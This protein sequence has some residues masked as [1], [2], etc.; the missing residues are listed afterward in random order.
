MCIACNPG[1]VAF[2]RSTASR[3]DFLKYL[4]AAAATSAFACSSPGMAFAQQAA[5]PAGDIVFK[6]GT[7]LTMNDKAPRA[8]AIAI[9]GNKIL[10]VGKLDDV[11]SAIGSGAQVVDLQ[12]RTL[13]PGLIDPHMHFVFTAFED[14]IDVSPI[15]TPDY[16][17]VWSKLQ[18]GV[19]DAKPG[20]WVRAQ[21][22]DASITRDAKIPTI[23]ELD[24]L[25]PNNPFFMQESNGHIAYANS[26]A[27]K[28]AGI[29]RETPDPSGA[30]FVKDA[31]GNLTGRLEEM[32]AQQEFLGVMPSPTAADMI[33]RVQRFLDHASSVGCTMLHDCGI[34]IMAG[35]QDL[36]I[37]DAVLGEGKAPVRYRGMLVSTI[38]DEWEKEGIKPGRGNDLFRVDGIKAWA[39]GS[40]QAQTGYQRENYLGTDERGA[41]NYS[42]EQVTE[43]IRRA[44]EGG[45]QVGVHA[46]GDAAID[47]VLDAYEAVL[48]KSSNSDLRHRIEHCSVFHPEQMVR[49]KDMGLSPS[50]LIGHVRWWG[51]AFRD[52]LLGPERARF[53]DP[54]AS[55]LA[56]GLKIS[57]HSDWNVTP[58]EPLRYVEDAVTRVMNEGGDV[59]FPEERIPVDAALRAVTIDAAWQCHM[60]DQI[61]SLETGKFADFAILEEDPTAP[62]VKIGKIKVSETWMDGTKRYA[63]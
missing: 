46:N 18:K 9:R 4:G 45:W 26:A 24:A 59:F 62:D 34:G 38:M 36:K 43:V 17:T 63:A 27:F 61:G 20:E 51:K 55:A 13:M 31:N 33:G 54:C 8:E 28:A 40:N 29:T 1:M 21:Q 44:H 12:G 47:M 42:L 11:Q 6:G 41:L 23:A 22:F 58:I 14:W 39:D 60:E 50:F 19:A 37:L 25:A 15:T 10:A 32:A 35:A 49:M 3:R 52:R 7:I 30:R 57:L 53:Y 56:A 5:A 16:A 2:L 48:G